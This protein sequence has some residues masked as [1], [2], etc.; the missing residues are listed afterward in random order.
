MK[1]AS[2]NEVIR[3]ARSSDYPASRLTELPT[4][5]CTGDAF[6]DSFDIA[7][8]VLGKEVP[9][10]ALLAYLFRRFGHPN[11]SSDPDKELAAYLLT[12][13]RPDMLL[14]IVPYAGG[15]VS[16]SFTFLVPHDVHI[17]CDDWESRDRD[18]HQ[19]A[20][21]D[22]IETEN[23]IPNWADKI[24]EEMSKGGWPI[25]AEMTGWRRMMPGIAMI[26][27]FGVRDEDPVDKVEAI[28]WY[29]AV[30]SD[31]EAK[32]PIPPM[33]WRSQ[34]VATWEDKDPMKPY[35]EAMAATLRDLL[36][37]VWIRDQAIG[38]YGPI[39]EEN[40]EALGN[41]GPDA[42]FAASAGFP[43]GDLGNQDPRGFA[44]LHA[45]VLR[46]HDDPST[47]IALAVALLAQNATTPADANLDIAG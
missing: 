9:Q 18:A 43:S 27:Y 3:L 14:K 5:V 47:A 41:K 7:E 12:T 33:Q 38:I 10:G 46:L 16:L 19:A 29:Q 31:Y 20:F 17:A 24:A 1:K 44:S 42:D 37:P 4:H 45:A 23:L 34:D 40:P 11:K 26:S 30:R 13:T 21:L 15:N 8:Q 28:H 6:S 39:D 36:R 35:A 25:H 32:H 2:R 22:W